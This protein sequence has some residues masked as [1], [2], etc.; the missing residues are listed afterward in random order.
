MAEQRSG[1][2]QKHSQDGSGIKIRPQGDA[3]SINRPQDD[4]KSINRPVQ[5]RLHLQRAISVYYDS[6]AKRLSPET[7]TSQKLVGGEDGEK[8]KALK[9][10]IKDWRIKRLSGLQEN[11]ELLKEIKSRERVVDVG[12]G[13]LDVIRESQ[14]WLRNWANGLFTKYK[15]GSKCEE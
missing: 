8:P 13:S 7:C 10:A 12:G 1:D 14:I 15:S 3:K 11:F 5:R 9:L 6:L 2:D 4:A